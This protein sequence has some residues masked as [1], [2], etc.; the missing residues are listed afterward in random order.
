LDWWRSF[1][2]P[3][4][5][6]LEEEALRGSLDLQAAVARVKQARA[7]AAAVRSQFYPVVTLDPSLTRARTSPGTH[8]GAATANTAVVPF[9]LTYEVDIWG[10][11][12][13]SV[14]AAKAQTRSA[15]DALEVVRQTLLAD[16]AQDYFTIR[17]LDDQDRIFARN[18]ELYRQQVTLT[19]TQLRAGL[20]GQTDVLQ[21]QTQLDQTLAQETDVRRQRA[22]AEHALA[23]LLGR[24]PASFTVPVLPLDLVPP[25]VPA[26]LP[27]DLL[28]R[29]PD[30]AGAE[31]DLAAASA[32]IGVARSAFFPVVMLT[33][34]AGFETFDVQHT[35]EWQNRVW[36]FGP[37]VSL[38]IFEG[39]KLQANLAQ[40]RGRYEELEAT[41]R[42][43]VLTAFG[44]VENA[45]TD[46]HHQADEALAQARAV[47]EAREYLRL[48]QLQYRQGL[49]NYLQVLD[50]DRTVLTNELSAAQTLNQRLASTVLL[51][52]ALGGGWE[53]EH[54]DPHATSAPAASAPAAGPR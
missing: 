50:A 48:S 13:R 39:G 3:R 14:E 8:F 5:T 40:A 12:S 2:D 43:A 49:I 19:Q 54:P 47:A 44:D 11:V 31:E 32:Q 29:R 22:D 16:V 33:G 23:I 45:L 27:G 30:V 9:D 35:F 25:V 7:A 21:A 4:L 51:I 28:R 34:A 15:A 17:S 46:L 36:S 38:P 41:Y 18:A 26:G 42:G 53:A 52:K 6:Q 1:G 37:S 10:Q 24:P 20:A